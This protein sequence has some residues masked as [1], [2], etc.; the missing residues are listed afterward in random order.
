VIIDSQTNQSKGY[1]F[2]SFREVRSAMKAVETMDGFLTSTGRRLK[3]QIKKGE[4]EAAAQALGIPVSQ[5]K[6]NGRNMPVCVGVILVTLL[7]DRGGSGNRA[8]P[9]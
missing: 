3:V 4:E 1:G 2:V 9:Y 8:T 5:V 7:A 6:A